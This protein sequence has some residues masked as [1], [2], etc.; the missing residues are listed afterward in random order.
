MTTRT[1]PS[2][3]FPVA[4]F[5]PLL[6]AA[7]LGA[8]VPA[9]AA[10]SA[11]VVGTELRVTGDAAGNVISLRL[12]PDT[13]RVEVRD[14]ALPV[15]S[16]LRTAF[17]TILVDAGGGNDDV[18]IDEIN[19]PFTTVH[20]T[21][22][23]GG[24]GLDTLVGGTG[25]E[26]IDGGPGRDTID[27]GP[28][29]D[30]LLGGEGNDTFTWDANPPIG[31]TTDA[32]DTIEG[33]EGF[34][35]LVVTG[36]A[37]AETFTL[38]SDGTRAVVA[39]GGVQIDAG[40]IERVEVRLQGGNDTFSAPGVAAPVL[41]VVRG[42]DGDD[43]ITGGA[44][45]DILWGDD[46]N[47][48]IDGGPGD[49][50]IQ[51]NAG[52][53]SLSGGAGNDTLQAFVGQGNDTS[54][55]GPGDDTLELSGTIASET[56]TVLDGPNVQVLVSPGAEIQTANT[57]E[58]I[59]LG[60]NFGDD[61]VNGGATS[62]SLHVHG[63]EGND[64]ITG[65]SGNDILDGGPGDDVIEGGDGDDV[66]EWRVN[67]EDDV[68][69]GQ[70]GIDTFRV[71]G[72]D[73]LEQV[74]VIRTSSRFRVD[75]GPLM[76][77]PQ[78]S[79]DVGTVERLEVVMGDG[80][81]ILSFGADLGGLLGR[82]TADLGG[83]A[84]LVSTTATSGR[85]LLDGGP[86]E[87]RLQFSALGQSLQEQPGT[88]AT[89]GS[90]RVTHANVEQLNILDTFGQVPTVTITTPTSAPATTST[91]AFVT[92]AGTVADDSVI[93][94][95]TWFNDRGGD[96]T[97]TG[98]NAWTVPNV[99]LQPGANVITVI[100]FDAFFN[101]SYDTIT[102]NVSTLTYFLAEGATGS[103]FDL[104]VLLANPTTTPA[105]VTVTFLRESGAPIVQSLTLA[106]TSRRTIHVDEVPG[107][108][109]QGGVSTTVTST[110]G[111][112]LVVE[113]TMFW[114]Q[115]Y[116]GSH[117]GTAVDGPRTRWLF[118]EG[119]EGFFNTFL[120]LANSGASAAT[121][122]LTFLREGTTPFAKVV[123]VPPAARVT[124]AANGIPELV[125][126]SFSI[127]VD[128]TQPI[129]AERAMYFGTARLFDG[130]HEST[131]VAEGSTSWFLAEGATGPFFETFVLVGNP[132]PVPAN[133]TFTFLTDAGVTVTR[134]K[135]IP[136]N[137]RLT[138]DIEGESPAL[139]NAAV[140][141]TVTADQPVVAERAMY[142]PGP[143]STW[144]EAHNSFGATAVSVK[145]GLAEGRVGMDHNF[146]TYILL[147]NPGTT[148][149]DVRIT[150]LR[151][152]G[153]TIV[154]TFTVAPSS[155]FNV[156]AGSAAP[157]LQN[158]TF[159]ALIEVTNGVGISVERA[160]YS[161]ALGQVW[162]AGTNALATPLP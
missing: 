148:A 63:Q 35:D 65:G 122:T 160:M 10:V 92:L 105:P 149:A 28:G 36:N 20:P 150:F 8:A 99:P 16:V 112:P 108:E 145:W 73:T 90:I 140:A 45:N 71:L 111:I 129:I 2:R 48:V 74:G 135:T 15:N 152:D 157:E 13:L 58:I 26:A 159:G 139:G 88:I 7:C 121:V 103:F 106:P 25:A 42:G 144:A 81:D 137:G 98:T 40:T 114:D 154:K 82:I 68:V 66:I 93:S 46:G 62:L 64:H 23:R 131:G 96:G 128:A 9:D 153:S 143:P 54:V 77:P 119:S 118:A 56:F 33:G 19:G 125:G 101:V 100:A 146:Q 1:R 79:E 11:S 115:T 61:T 44:G 55:G 97:A 43:H 110:A 80:D 123:E 14:G 17:T 18:T 120:L 155:R 161:D 151:G 69:D 51:G 53:D 27:G 95:V 124:V 107:L 117:G 138:V 87:D 162:A 127:V 84:D 133:V 59:D 29:N 22:L 134:T 158:E 6:A 21:T 70:G 52:T 141:T 34:D 12:S 130:G 126:R 3:R 132:N 24:D 30:T 5:A 147:A 142:W 76:N 94:Q 31:F 39:R 86:G 50:T 4:G 37:L 49:D 109:S 136:A 75:Y 102:V 32:N 156:D 47:D 83:G 72:S 38:T 85:L 116:Y 89:Q 104:D 41:L 57:V 60:L 91:S 113:R 67:G 78:H